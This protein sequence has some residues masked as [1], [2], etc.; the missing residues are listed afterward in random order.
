MRRRTFLLDSGRAL[1]GGTLLSSARRAIASE[2][3]LASQPQ[4]WN[5]LIAD[6]ERQIP[7]LMRDA[8]VPGLS[9]AIIKDARVFWRRAFGV[10]DVATNAA[11]DTD[12]LF[13]AASTSKPV[14][15]Y[16]S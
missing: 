13:E 15:A 16:A 10:K 2:R 8:A 3:L 9:M 12:T 4:P 1:L 11:V 6:L 14:F 5:D 7:L